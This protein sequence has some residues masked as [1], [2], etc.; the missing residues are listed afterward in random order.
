MRLVRWNPRA[1]ANFGREFD[2]LLDTVW[3]TRGKGSG[4]WHPR[5]DVT[6]N[7]NAF[8]ILAELPGLSREDISVT[9][10]DNLLTI[11]GEK[12]RSS[13]DNENAAHRSERS[14]GRFSR[15]FKLSTNVNAEG[16]SAV[17]KDGVLS[18]TLTKAEAAKPKE[19]EVVAA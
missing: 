6:E 10:K 15:S 4:V 1:A 14:F 13:E 11:E 16:I 17:H 7:E 19:I 5:V 8:V 9:V 18:L 3:G 12:R 2:E